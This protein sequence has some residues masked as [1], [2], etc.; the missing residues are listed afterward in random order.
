MATATMAGA[1]VQ[2]NDRFY[3]EDGSFAKQSAEGTLCAP[4][5]PK[6]L[7]RNR[8]IFWTAMRERADRELNDCRV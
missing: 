6:A 1:K 2:V 5:D 3:F 8:L 7:A 4:T